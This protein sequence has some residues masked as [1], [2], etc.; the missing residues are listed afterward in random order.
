MIIEKQKRELLEEALKRIP[1][2]GLSG[3][4]LKKSAEGIGLE[5][6]YAYV[7]FPGGSRE[8][9]NYFSHFIDEKLLDSV[10][11]ERFA[12]IGVAAKITYMVRLRLE[13]YAPYKEAVR[14]FVSYNILPHH[15]PAASKMLWAT[16]DNIWH[17]AG[18]QSTDYNYYT[19]RII[20]S[21]VYCTTLVYWLNDDSND[22]TKTW[23]F[24]DSRIKD[25]L[26]IGNVKKL[27]HNFKE[28]CKDI[29]FVRLLA[30]KIFN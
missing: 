12:E 17:L 4:T 9:L 29:P 5:P 6:G 13:L 10:D 11:K 16:A 20:L 18:D 3:A 23:D 8:F 26:K 25:A 30:R 21:A 1:F 2:D 15:T 28:K 7:L 14:S 27:M 24:L 19:K 22:C